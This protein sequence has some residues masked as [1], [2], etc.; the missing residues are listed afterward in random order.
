MTSFGRLIR[1]ADWLG[2]VAARRLPASPDAANTVQPLHNRCLSAGRAVGP[3][4]G[5]RYQE[6]DHEEFEFGGACCI[7]SC[8]YG[9]RRPRWRSDWSES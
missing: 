7:P 6:A 2:V 9:G 1:I 8:R 5:K 4:G 3:N